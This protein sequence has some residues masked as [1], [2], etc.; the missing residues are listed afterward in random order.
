MSQWNNTQMK[1]EVR[2]PDAVNEPVID[3]FNTL[4]EAKEYAESLGRN[5]FIRVQLK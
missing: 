5:Y 4:S 3:S 2:D 1:F